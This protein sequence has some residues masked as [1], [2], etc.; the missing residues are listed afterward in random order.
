V[1]GRVSAAFDMVL[2]ADCVCVEEMV[3]ASVEGED[4]AVESEADIAL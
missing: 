2:P 1:K 4:E 3:E